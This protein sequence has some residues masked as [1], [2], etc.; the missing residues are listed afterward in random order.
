MA[1]DRPPTR[2][3]H[4]RAGTRAA[5]TRRSAASH[6]RDD[7]LANSGIRCLAP[8]HAVTRLRSASDPIRRTPKIACRDKPARREPI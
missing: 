5:Y 6:Q 8:M 3:A 2:R 4:R 1:D 7:A